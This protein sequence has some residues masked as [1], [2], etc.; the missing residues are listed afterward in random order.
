[1][2]KLMF[3]ALACVAF[4]FSGFASNE[5]VNENEVINENE[6]INEELSINDTI[7]EFDAACKQWIEVARTCGGSFYLC[8]DNYTTPKELI[9]AME[10]YNSLQCYGLTPNT[11][12]GTGIGKF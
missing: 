1:M 3:S 11:G 4:A 5:V 10:R 7:A 9:D 2:K 6:L 8:E 12:L